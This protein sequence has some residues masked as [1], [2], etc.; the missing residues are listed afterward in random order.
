MVNVLILE[1]D[2]YISSDIKMLV[3][4][5][6]GFSGYIASDMPS[7]LKISQNNPIQIA[8]CDI[9]IKGLVDGIDTAQMLQNLYRCQV[10]F[11]TSFCDEMTLAKAAKVDFSGY[12]L[13]P[14]REEELLASLKLCA[15]KSSLNIVGYEVSDEYWFDQKHQQL[16]HHNEAVN[17]TSKEQQ[18]FLLLLHTR[19]KVVPL[20]Y[21][22]EIIWHEGNVSDTTR[23]QLLHRLKTKLP[24]L[25]FKIVKYA[26][27]MMEV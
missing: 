15:L 3:D 13:K 17:L 16:F 5:M 20:S 2:P 24:N 22:D 7:A 1:D 27:Y 10:V 21:I 8:L 25:S 14:F 18:L 4:E 19:G 9:Q 23:R 12:I 11:L 26:G 6:E